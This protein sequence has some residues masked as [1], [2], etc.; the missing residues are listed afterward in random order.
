LLPSFNFASCFPTE[1]FITLR[2]LDLKVDFV[3][4][5]KLLGPARE[6]DDFW[7]GEKGNQS[8]G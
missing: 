1:P 3:S 7:I 5:L 4:D 6:N 2:G 8:K